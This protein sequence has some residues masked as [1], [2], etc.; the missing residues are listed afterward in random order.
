MSKLEK[1]DKLRIRLIIIMVILLVIMLSVIVMYILPKTSPKYNAGYKA[2]PM[3][4]YY[5]LVKGKVCSPDDIYNSIKVKIAVNKLQSYDFYLIANDE[6]T[7][8]FM[9]AS[10]LKDDVDWQ[11]EGINFRGPLTAMKTLIDESGNRLYYIE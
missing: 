11:L 6:D 3:S 8:T 9:M 7:A 5:C 10:N 2:R 1:L 4:N